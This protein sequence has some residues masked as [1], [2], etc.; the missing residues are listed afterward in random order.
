MTLR[1]YLFLMV[2][3]TALCWFGWYLVI[4]DVDPIGGGWLSLA[5]FYLSLS[6]AAVGTL[7]VAGLIGRAVFRPH[8]AVTRH[9]MVSF[10]QGILLTAVLVAA[11]ILQSFSKLG[12]GNAVLLIG[13][14]TLI[15]VFFASFKA[16]RS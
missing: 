1:Q 9:V 4:S 14:A 5:I 11:L 15:E 16:E 6:L 7:A 12:W 8:E 13:A 3:T 2:V 10:R